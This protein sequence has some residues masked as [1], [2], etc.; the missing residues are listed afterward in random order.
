[1]GKVSVLILTYNEEDRIEDCLKS[2]I[3]ADE[4]VVLD[5]FSTDR[6]LEIVEKYP[7]KIIQQKWLGFAKQRNL[8]LNYCSHNWILVVDADERVTQELQKEI[9]QILEQDGYSGYYISRRTYFL[10]KWIKH[11]GWYPDYVLR[12]FCKERGKYK[13]Q[14]VH[15]S[16]K[17]EGRIGYCKSD[18]L[19][20]T[21]RDI[22]HYLEKMNQYS[23]LA[24][25]QM[26]D[27]GKKINHSTIFFRPSW[28]WLKIYFLRRGFLDGWPGLVISIISA[29]Y[30]WLKYTKLYSLVHYKEGE[31]DAGKTN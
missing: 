24:A 6:T 3:W 28:A 21:Y 17:L 5:S 31:D 27:E 18:L 25:C 20:Y 22:T 2:V 23:S 11:C 13:E 15:E 12:L 4:I 14:M 1:M 26:L 16:V 30:V 8:G 7:A 19:H 29:F 9:R 10:G